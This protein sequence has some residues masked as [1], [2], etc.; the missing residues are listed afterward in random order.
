MH[1]L[2]AFATPERVIWQPYVAGF[3]ADAV[4]TE[5]LQ[6]LERRKII[7]KLKL[8]TRARFRAPAATSDGASA[9]GEMGIA[10]CDRITP[11]LPF[12]ARACLTCSGTAGARDQT[13]A[14]HMGRASPTHA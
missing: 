3:A 5:R 14:N 8:L 7:A 11:L 2:P 12:P 9:S 13:A 10:V 4:G 6:T 1:V